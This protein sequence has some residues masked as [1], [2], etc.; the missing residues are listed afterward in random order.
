MVEKNGESTPRFIGLW[1]AQ[2]RLSESASL[3]CFGHMCPKMGAPPNKV[4]PGNYN[5]FVGTYAFMYAKQC[6]LHIPEW[7]QECL[8]PQLVTCWHCAAEQ[9]RTHALHAPFLC[10]VMHWLC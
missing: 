3:V 5:M 10:Q 6:L 1:P 7:C 9:S 2:R 8:F 4:V